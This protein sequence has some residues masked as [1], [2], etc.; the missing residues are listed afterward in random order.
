MKYLISLLIVSIS[1]L[2][3]DSSSAQHAIA[4]QR[5]AIGV[6]APLTGEAATY[7]EDIR[8]AI[9]YAADTLG[10]GRYALIVEDDEC[11][12]SAAATVA[13]K[14]T[15]VDKVGYV[16]GF[17]CSGA[18]LA[19]APIYERSKTVTIGVYTSSPKVSEAGE[20]I[21]RTVPSDTFAAVP[22][23]AYLKKRYRNVGAIFEETDF[24]QDFRRALEEQNRAK[25]LEMRTE[26]F[27]PGSSDF[28]SLLLRLRA[29]GVDA[30]V[31]IPQA[32]NQLALIR[33]QLQELNWSVPLFSHVWPSS[34]A[35]LNM[36][37]TL[38]NGIVF[39]DLPEIEEVIDPSGRKIYEGFVARYGQPKSSAMAFLASYLAFNALHQAIQSGD[40]VRSYLLSHKFD[41]L[42]GQYS[43][44]ANGDI[45]GL[46]FVLKT[47]D[48]GKPRSLAA[49]EM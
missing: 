12:G 39:T 27:L 28:R 47:I 35:F 17:G 48:D 6:S 40:N 25:S 4:P 2:V 29:S 30:L 20:F 15:K 5:I 33:K 43:F 42:I 18:L 1:L 8:N 10:A 37:G 32:E 34:S 41:A 44:D 19:A 22:L 11:S 21:F 24:A 16:V 3:V 31:A 49:A 7:G 46:G 45:Q 14:L 13:Q 23:S 36:V 26:N 9:Q 38:A